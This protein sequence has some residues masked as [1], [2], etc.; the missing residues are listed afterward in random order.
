[1][2]NILACQTFFTNSLHKTL[3]KSLNKIDKLKHKNAEKLNNIIYFHVIFYIYLT[4]A[5]KSIENNL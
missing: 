2:K 5:S 3:N 1:M 4:I